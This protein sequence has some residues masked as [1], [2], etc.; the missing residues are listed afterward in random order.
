MGEGIV[1]ALV[2]AGGVGLGAVLT[3]LVA[4]RD[5]ALRR[6]MQATDAFMRIAARAHGYRE[7]HEKSTVG[8]SE[9]IAAI[10][11]LA[12]L[13]K[14]FRWLRPACQAFLDDEA[15]WLDTTMGDTA[16]LLKAA[17]IA[18][19]ATIPDRAP[20]GHGAVAPPRVS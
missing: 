14:K 17:V 12:G 16:V 3:W 9:Q 5:L 2:A 6:R 11:L 19:R 13:G 4:T 1:V 8:S 7:N 10:Y 18:A 15:R 20:R